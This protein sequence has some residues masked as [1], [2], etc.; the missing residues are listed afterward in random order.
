MIRKL[1]LLIATTY[2]AIKHSNTV[3]ISWLNT[4]KLYYKDSNNNICSVCRC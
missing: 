4:Y 3:P 1:I 2:L